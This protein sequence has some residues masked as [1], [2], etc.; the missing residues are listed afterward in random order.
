MKTEVQM[1][2]T[3]RSAHAGISQGHLQLSSKQNSD[4]SEGSNLAYQKTQKN[5]LGEGLKL[6]FHDHNLSYC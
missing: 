4:Y 5:L 2:D 1:R 3:F 6:N